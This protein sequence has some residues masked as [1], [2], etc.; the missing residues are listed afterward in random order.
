MMNIKLKQNTNT[1]N[2]NTLYMLM[3]KAKVKNKSFNKL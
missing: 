1:W 3:Q 2:L